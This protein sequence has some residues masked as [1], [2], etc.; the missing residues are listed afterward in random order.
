MR[1]GPEEEGWLSCSWSFRQQDPGP[2]RATAPSQKT[3]PRKAAEDVSLNLSRELKETR[4][5]A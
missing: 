5:C 4:V 2:P 3:E 1:R